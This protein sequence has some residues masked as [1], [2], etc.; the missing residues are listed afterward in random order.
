MRSGFALRMLAT[1]AAGALAAYLSTAGWL[2]SAFVASFSKSQLELWQI[3]GPLLMIFLLAGFGAAFGLIGGTVLLAVAFAV[4]E[5][6]PLGWTHQRASMA[7]G[8]A[9]GAMFAALAHLPDI[10]FVYNSRHVLGVW[11]LRGLMRQ[12]PIIAVWASLIPPL[13]GVIAGLAYNGL[14][15]R[16]GRGPFRTNLAAEAPSP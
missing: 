15:P 14:A 7:A 12:G 3:P 11:F 13:A 1:V 8:A 2:L 5:R 10:N 4:A 9:A 16:P 6:L